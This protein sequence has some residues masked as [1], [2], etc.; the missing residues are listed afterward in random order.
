MA[1]QRV[2][3]MCRVAMLQTQVYRV[4]SEGLEKR[5]GVILLEPGGRRPAQVARKAL[6]QAVD[7]AKREYIV[8][9]IESCSGGQKVYWEAVRALNG[10]DSRA[11]AVALQK[12]LDADGVEC[13]TPKGKAEVAA[14]HFMKV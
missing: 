9:M 11:T 1:Q 5:T 2:R 8:S 6:K 14:K 12:F 4:T 10:D 3:E 7:K 13:A